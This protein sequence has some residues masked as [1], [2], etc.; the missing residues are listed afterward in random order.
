VDNDVGLLKRWI[1][2]AV[3][4]LVALLGR[5]GCVPASP[6]SEVLRSFPGAC[7]GV[8]NNSK[9]LLQAHFLRVA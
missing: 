7:Q 3:S 9:A 5:A 2:E 8:R 4:L 6:L 1:R